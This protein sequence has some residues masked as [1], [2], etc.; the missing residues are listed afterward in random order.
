VSALTAMHR[1]DYTVKSI[2]EHHKTLPKRHA[3]TGIPKKAR[4]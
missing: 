3:P 2:Q 4:V 1:A